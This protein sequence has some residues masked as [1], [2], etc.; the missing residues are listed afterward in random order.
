MFVRILGIILPVFLI[1]AIGYGYGRRARPDMRAFNRIVLDVLVPLLVFSAL[2]S[3][4]FD[5]IANRALLVGSIVVVLGSGL[6]AWP[7]CLLIGEDP[8]TFVPPMMFN[9]C[10]N[11]GLP[12]SVLA[13]GAAG[14]G[15]AVALFI[16][17][18]L[19]HFT[20]GARI[21]SPQASMWAV[22]RSPIVLATVI[23]TI[24]ALLHVP[25]PPEIM[26][27]VKLMGD[28]TIPLMLFSLGVRLLSIDL[29]GWA[30]GLVA[31]VVCPVGGLLAAWLI[32]PW[33]G[34]NATQYGL[35]MLFA[36][37]PPAVLNFLVAEQYQQ[38]PE[39]V[40]SIV[41][42]GNLGALVFVP[43]GLAAGLPS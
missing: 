39:K 13:F 14:L 30:L 2:A 17:S 37:L 26:L 20:L 33:L 3:K 18:N 4:D 25:V 34:L 7:V 35:L 38:E 31:A 32:A 11:M 42:F 43:I 12:L 9:N 23:G 24:F 19:L 40:A 29:R 15:P 16:V 1:V 27:T 5:L 6:L 28:A 8:K 22:F 41:L 36:S 21:V 10:G